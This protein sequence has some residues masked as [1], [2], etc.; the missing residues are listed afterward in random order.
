MAGSALAGL[1]R[2]RARHTT[3][4]SYPCGT[5]WHHGADATIKSRQI[6]APT[7]RHVTF[8]A[9][10]SGSTAAR[11][12]LA[13]SAGGRRCLRPNDGGPATNST[14]ECSLEVRPRE[15][16]PVGVVLLPHRG[17]LRQVR[18]KVARRRAGWPPILR[19][20]DLPARHRPMSPCAAERRWPGN[21]PPR[22]REYP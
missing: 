9:H 13:D 15:H 22:L 5:V 12:A 20:R 14:P 17:Q 6:P 8:G 3:S 21:Q 2:R 18:T 11:P 19:W 7:P 4:A 10:K 1:G 16:D